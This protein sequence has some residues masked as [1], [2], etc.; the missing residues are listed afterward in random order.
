MAVIKSSNMT[1]KEHILLDVMG[2]DIIRHSGINSGRR[3]AYQCTISGV[4]LMIVMWLPS[5]AVCSQAGIPCRP[6]PP[7]WPF[8]GLIRQTVF[9][10]TQTLIYS[11]ILVWHHFLEQ[12]QPWLLFLIFTMLCTVP[13]N[14]C[15]WQLYRSS[16]NH[17]F[18]PMKSVNFMIVHRRPPVAYGSGP[19]QKNTL[20]S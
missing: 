16:P 5:S 11:I 6:K 10:V 14:H 1:L 2:L 17:W 12:C 19:G 15:T 13:T 7:S 3:P 4:Y 9:P 8:P 20:D 18:F